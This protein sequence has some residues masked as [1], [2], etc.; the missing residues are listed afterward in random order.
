[1]ATT[2]KDPEV[3]LDP[4]SNE[5]SEGYPA[6]EPAPD[7]DDVPHQGSGRQAPQVVKQPPRQMRRIVIE[8]DG[9]GVRLVEANVAGA[10]EL[11]A[12]FRA[13]AAKFVPKEGIG[14]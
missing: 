1:M 6:N 9:N 3:K 7:V 8:T 2:E 14:G 4:D 10:I 11:G 13:L 12:I 5:K